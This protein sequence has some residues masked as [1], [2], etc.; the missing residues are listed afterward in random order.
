MTL[1]SPRI[2][3]KTRVVDLGDLIREYP[4]GTRIDRYEIIATL[5]SGGCGV[6]YS[7][8]HVH[9]DQI[10]ALK[11]LHRGLIHSEERVERFFREARATAA[12][13]NPHIVRVSDCGV[14]DEG[15]PFLAME[16]LKGAVLEDLIDDEKPLD[17]ARAVDI[18]LQI[19]DGLAAA[20][21]AGVVHRDLKPEN[22]FLIRIAEGSQE[23]VK[24]VDF[25]VS[26][27]FKDSA[28]FEKVLTGTG[29]LLGTPRYMS[30]E[31]F[32]G[33]KDVDH[34]ADLFAAAVVLYQMLSGVL[35]FEG[36][37]ALE[38]AHKASTQPPRPLESVAPDVPS[39]LRAMILRGLEKD[40]N[41]RWA[42]ARE[43]ADALRAFADV[44]PTE[45]SKR[46]STTVRG[47]SSPTEDDDP[48]FQSTPGAVDQFSRPL[49]LVAPTARNVDLLAAVEGLP[50]VFEDE[51]E[52]TLRT[53]GNL[54]ALVESEDADQRA[55]DPSVSPKGM[56]D[57]TGESAPQASIG[58]SSSPSED[59][60]RE[61]ATDGAISSE[62]SSLTPDASAS[63]IVESLQEPPNDA[64]S[65]SV[66]RGTLTPARLAIA[67]LGLLSLVGGLA[68][69]SALVSSEWF[70]EDSSTT[71]DTPVTDT[72]VELRVL[73]LDGGLDRAAVMA[74]LESARP[75]LG[76]CSQPDR[77]EEIRLEA[78]VAPPGFSSGRLSLV[79]AAPGNSASA[80]LVQCCAEAVRAG[81]PADWNPGES[82][83]ITFDVVLPG[84]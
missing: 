5:G 32:R 3:P 44:A 83:V 52:V 47:M 10:V 62:S 17:V 70:A 69:G 13:G 14:D 41:A 82:G 25:G 73:Q 1:S 9:L 75:H 29:V 64:E 53:G 21:D 72:T 30:P 23:F 26:K 57:P 49:D 60:R 78:H 50:L 77:V 24:I 43:F 39:A 74:A 58:T 2:S 68:V 15:I 22:I 20:H 65:S 31:Q 28:S 8:R 11:L 54:A 27:V 33:A 71:L 67:I 36:R 46:T 16:F 51:A 38:L 55:T 45:R 12:I 56:S 19:L 7:A 48:T 66:R 79:R 6:V 37:S 34:R 80:E 63:S 35:P 40:P 81:V 84:R 42:T 76:M 61:S 18:E 59:S 4:Q